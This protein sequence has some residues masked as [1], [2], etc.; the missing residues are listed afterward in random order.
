MERRKGDR[1][2]AKWQIAKLL[3]YAQRRCSSG[4]DIVIF[5][6][7]LL[8]CQPQLRTENHN[9][10]YYVSTREWAAA[11]VVYSILQ[12]ATTSNNSTHSS[13]SVLSTC[14]QHTT[15]T[16]SCTTCKHLSLKL[17]CMHVCMYNQ[18][19]R[20]LIAETCGREQPS[21]GE[22]SIGQCCHGSVL[23]R[24]QGACGS[25]KGASKSHSWP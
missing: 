9:K 5:A 14:W 16:D 11:K 23:G 7:S 15:T 22:G 1:T 4:I 19:T 18:N 2:L 25:S 17:Y 24:C 21:L 8:T 13:K 6:W 12:Y 3:H 20:K 10:R